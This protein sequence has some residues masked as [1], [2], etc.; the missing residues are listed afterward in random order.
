[1][2]PPLTHY[3]LTSILGHASPSNDCILISF[4]TRLYREQTIHVSSLARRHLKAFSFFLP[5]ISSP[6]PSSSPAHLFS[7]K[8][9]FSPRQLDL[10][11][12]QKAVFSAPWTVQLVMDQKLSNWLHRTK[13]PIGSERGQI[14]GSRG[15]ERKQRRIGRNEE[16]GREKM[17]GEDRGEWK[18]GRV[19]R[20]GKLGAGGCRP[21]G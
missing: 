15:R 3:V 12:P 14:G 6:S 18:R 16:I 1:M 8:S 9:L 11:L 10:S 20:W 17:K 13:G 5:F 4:W 21:F 19:G 2:Q 7:E